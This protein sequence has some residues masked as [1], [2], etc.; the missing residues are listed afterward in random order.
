MMEKS[1]KYTIIIPHYNTPKLLERC[2]VSIPED[3]DIQVIVADDNSPGSE[4]Y[5]DEYPCLFRKNVEFIFSKEKQR[6]GGGMRNLALEKS[7]GDWLIFA[8][9]DDFFVDDFRD[10]LDCYYNSTNDIVYFNIRSCREDS[11][12]VEVPNNKE[13]LFTIYENTK[14]DRYFRYSHTQP[15]GKMIRLSL[16]RDN[17][18]CF[19]ET[20]IANDFLFSVKAGYYAHKVEIV[21]RPLYWYVLMNKSTSNGISPLKERVRFREFI[22]VQKFLDSKNVKSE[23][24]LISYLFEINFLSNPNKF[25]NDFHDLK[26]SEYPVAKVLWDS[27]LLKFKRQLH[28]KSPKHVERKFL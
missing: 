23:Y 5:I 4:K 25:Y 19:E 8:D 26:D 17:N 21:D 1:Y 15:W 27:L 24:N 2:L 14:D 22:K 13:K 3:D 10:I 12:G 20:I 9:S 7:S 18:I 16:V 11:I 6:G 28:R